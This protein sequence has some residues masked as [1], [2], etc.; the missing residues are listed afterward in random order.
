MPCDYSTRMRTY[1]LH[2]GIVHSLRTDRHTLAIR[3]CDTSVVDGVRYGSYLPPAIVH[4]QGARSHTTAYVRSAIAS[5][6]IRCQTIG[7]TACVPPARRDCAFA[8]DR[9]YARHTTIRRA[10]DTECLPLGNQRARRQWHT[11]SCYHNQRM[12][13]SC[14]PSGSRIRLSCGIDRA[15]DT[16]CTP[17]TTNERA[18]TGIPSTNDGHC[19]RGSD[20]LLPLPGFGPLGTGGLPECA[21]SHTRTDPHPASSSPSL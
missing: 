7:P 10:C 18:T 21:S 15:Y 9:S 19:P 11:L 12:R 13:T 16:E 8:E 14:V 3:P 1:C 2:E 17:S 4:S 6:T 20:A 5:P